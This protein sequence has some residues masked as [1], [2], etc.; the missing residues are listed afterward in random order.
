MS[1]QRVKGSHQ[2]SSQGTSVLKVEAVDGDKGIN[3]IVT[4]SITSENRVV[5]QRGLG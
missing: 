4:Y 1:K 2:V 3:D 5:P